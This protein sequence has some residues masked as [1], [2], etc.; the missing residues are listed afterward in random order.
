MTSSVLY[1]TTHAGVAL[2]V[3][4]V[5]NP[6][7]RVAPTDAELA[8]MSEQYLIELARVQE[9]P[10]AFREALQRSALARA[11]MAA[12]D[13]FLGGM[14]TYLVKLGPD[15]LGADASQIDRHIAG[16][17]PAFSARLRLQDMAR[18]LADSLS[19][20]IAAGPQRPVCLI[21]IGGGPAS[22]SW[23]ALIC[24]HAAHSDL[25]AGREITI[26]VMDVDD[27][28]PAFG[29]RAIETLCAPTAPLS[30]LHIE[31]R[32]FTY[33]WSEADRL[34]DVLDQLHATG[35]ACFVSSEG[36]LFEYGSDADIVS[37]L[38][39]LNGGTAADTIVVGSVTRDG[40]P[41]RALETASRISTRPRTIEAFRS[42]TEE[43][44]WVVQESLERAFT[45]NLRL[46]KA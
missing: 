2:P 16:T 42:L 35:A 33:D 45:Y 23:N 9:I 41:M 1:A 39:M 31:F 44:G 8:A 6:A 13:R 5:T 24:L 28:G 32:H 4:D 7:F 10:A 11:L 34:G 25:L 3:I 46:M 12:R 38:K 43:A 22:D 29:A 36:A 37:N 26:A 14:D 17:F 30:G 21:N 20:S 15:N 27:D 18:M 19:L 40:A